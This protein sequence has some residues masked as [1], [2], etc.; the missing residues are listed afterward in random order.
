MAAIFFLNLCLLDS[1]NVAVSQRQ[2]QVPLSL[3]QADCNEPT[4]MWI[5]WSI[6]TENKVGKSTENP[7]AILCPQPRWHRAVLHPSHAQVSSQCSCCIICSSEAQSPHLLSGFWVSVPAA[8][9]DSRACS[10]FQISFCTMTLTTGWIS[11]LEP[12]WSCCSVFCASWLYSCSQDGI[13]MC[14]G[15]H[16]ASTGT[17]C[18]CELTVVWVLQL[19]LMWQSVFKPKA[20]E[21]SWKVPAGYSWFLLKQMKDLPL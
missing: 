16:P 19:A 10:I 2:T 15:I 21:V 20:G 17:G 18:V 3:L 11:Y 12:G 8:S 1:T 14:S 6:L 4:P 13:S 9:A 5:C 7:Q